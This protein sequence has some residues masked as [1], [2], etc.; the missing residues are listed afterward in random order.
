MLRLFLV[1]Q[2]TKFSSSLYKIQNSATNKDF[3]GIKTEAP[4]NKK[5]G[6]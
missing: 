3:S 5:R 2:F 4:I 1:F 6:K